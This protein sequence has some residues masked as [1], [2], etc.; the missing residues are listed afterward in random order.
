LGVNQF[1]ACGSDDVPSSDMSDAKDSTARCSA[2][3]SGNGAMARNQVCD[4]GGA[5]FGLSQ[6]RAAT[7]RIS[8]GR[9]RR[10]KGRIASGISSSRAR[11]SSC[12]D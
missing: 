5:S 3:S 11:R 10:K 6:S 7:G 2:G 9:R 4:S 8:I 1:T 12:S